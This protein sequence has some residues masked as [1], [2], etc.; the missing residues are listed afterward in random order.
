MIKLEAAR[1]QDWARLYHWRN[2]PE[3]RAAS[4]ET[5]I[6]PL[7]EHLKWLKATLAKDATRLFVAR[8][9]MMGYV[10]TGRVDRINAT[11][12]EV[13]LTVAPEARGQGYALTLLQLLTEEA[14]R[15]P[16][17]VALVKAVV[18]A[19]NYRSLRTFADAGYEV[20]RVKNGLVDL[21]HD[22]A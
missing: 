12:V 17:K 21:T 8:D 19:D 13:S 22:G 20:V 14:V 2:D 6:V 18:K 16:G 9:P 3:T 5:D 11:T 10:G 1:L 15:F 4:V 7:D